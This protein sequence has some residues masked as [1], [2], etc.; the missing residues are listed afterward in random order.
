MAATTD[1]R[2][3][4][5]A[6]LR[7]EIFDLRLQ[8][9]E[10]ELRVAGYK[11]LIEDI[12]GNVGWLARKVLASW[13][14]TDEEA[15]RS[16]ISTHKYKDEPE[17]PRLPGR[18]RDFVYEAAGFSP[19]DDIVSLTDLSFVTREKVA[20]AKGVGPTTMAALDEAM[21]DAGLSWTESEAVTS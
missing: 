1:E 19:L 7:D 17:L 12:A 16:A 9:R 18:S 8:L 15:L 10:Q 6:S 2:D 21:A 20:S 3:L 5:A 4:L 14:G 11:R 13:K